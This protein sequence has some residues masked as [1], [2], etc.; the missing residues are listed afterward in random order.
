MQQSTRLKLY[1]TCVLTTDVY[2]TDINCSAWNVNS[3][4]LLDYENAL[5]VLSNMKDDMDRYTRNVIKVLLNFLDISVARVLQYCMY[6]W[7]CKKDIATKV[8]NLINAY[9]LKFNELYGICYD[10]TTSYRDHDDCDTMAT[11]NRGIT[12]ISNID[13]QNNMC[14]EYL[15][16]MDDSSQHTRISLIIFLLSHYNYYERTLHNNY[17][18]STYDFNVQPY[19]P[20]LLDIYDIAKVLHVY[21]ALISSNLKRIVIQTFQVTLS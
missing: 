1:I 19:M 16:M 11:S 13:T 7:Q 18:Y 17:L 3:L 4:I 14:D 20:S 12:Q 2:S 8:N 21:H 15:S 6:H 9:F 10:I 5:K